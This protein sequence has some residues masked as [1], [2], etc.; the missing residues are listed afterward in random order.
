[1]PGLGNWGP[2][3]DFITF[4]PN[5]QAQSGMTGLTGYPG[6][7]PVGVGT[8]WADYLAGAT[9]STA[10]LC[11]IEHRQ[12]TGKG[13]FIDISQQ[14]ACSAFLGDYLL[15]WEANREVREN[16]GNH[17]PSGAAAPHGCYRCRGTERWCVIS[18]A[19]D[20]EWKNFCEALGNP[21]WTAEERF[22]THLSRVRFQDDVDALVGDWTKNLTPEE[23]T[24]VMQGA[25]VSAGVVQN[26]EDLINHDKHLRKRGFLV[27]FKM[28]HPERKPAVITLPGVITRF[29]GI[30]MTIRRPAPGRLGEDNEKLLKEMLG[31]GRKEYEQAEAAGAFQ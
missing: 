23:V 20:R 31:M 21:E 29:S 28:P 13:Q 2:Y 19:G 16:Y 18:V 4:G 17:H 25:G 24:S 9:M 14:E 11:A 8:P 1:M 27:D 26:A 22:A 5:L 6:M 30:P 12:R 7:E 10:I 3:S 15:D